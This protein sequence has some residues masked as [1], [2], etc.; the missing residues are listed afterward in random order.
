MLLKK[1]IS[2]DDLVQAMGER[3]AIRKFDS[4]K[5]IA[6][7]TMQALM[8]CFRL[9]P[10]SC[11]LQPW[12]LVLVTNK[13]I[14]EK[15]NEGSKGKMTPIESANAVIVLCKM[16]EM[17]KSYIV[18]YSRDLAER[19]QMPSIEESFIKFALYKTNVER[20]SWLEDQVY[21]ALGSIITA[22]ALLGV[23]CLPM[24][25]GDKNLWDNLL[26]LNETGYTATVACLL[27]IRDETD[28]FSHL[29]KVRKSLDELVIRIE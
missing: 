1:W 13:K 5:T 7:E 24:E 15:M 25:D 14:M 9:T 28:K 27:G 3:K 4:T 17:P 29:P 23:D 19:W 8:E 2:E 11:G 18:D 22:C 26:G 10:S 16:T 12:K 6:P 21:I 20:A